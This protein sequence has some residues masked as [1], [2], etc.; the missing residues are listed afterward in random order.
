VVSSGGYQ[1]P[2]VTVEETERLQAHAIA[3][4]KKL[5]ALQVGVI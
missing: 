5:I 4:L 3:E 1:G 2:Q